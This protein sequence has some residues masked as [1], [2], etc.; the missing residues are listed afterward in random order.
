MSDGSALTE[1]RKI[2]MCALLALAMSLLSAVVLTV[3]T[4]IASTWRAIMSWMLDSSRAA[5]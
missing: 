1:V 2:G 5:S 3:C 4:M